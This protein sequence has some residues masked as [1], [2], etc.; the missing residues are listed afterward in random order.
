MFKGKCT[1]KSQEWM[2]FVWYKRV[3]CIKCKN[4]IKVE[5]N[6]TETVLFSNCLSSGS[7][8]GEKEFQTCFHIQSTGLQRDGSQ[9][10]AEPAKP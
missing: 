10:G 8:A 2:Y 9:P 5:K 7:Q 1:L 6:T 4:V 3:V